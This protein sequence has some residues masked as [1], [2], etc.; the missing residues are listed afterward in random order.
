MNGTLTLD[1]LAIVAD[2]VLTVNPETN[3]LEANFENISAGIDGIAV[4]VDGLFGG[5][6]GGALQGTLDSFAGDIETLL[7]DE[8]PSVLGP[9]VGDT[10]SSLAFEFDLELPSLSTPRESLLRYPSRRISATPTSPL[11]EG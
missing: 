6:I 10:L 4:D 5:L 2:V 9:V 3:A 11:Q 7:V 8:I 1:A